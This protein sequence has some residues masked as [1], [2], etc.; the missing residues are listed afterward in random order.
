MLKELACLQLLD[1]IFYFVVLLP[2]GMYCLRE[3]QGRSTE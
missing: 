1:P 2:F 3:G